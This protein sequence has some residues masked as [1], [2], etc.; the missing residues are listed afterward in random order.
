M[1]CIIQAR[2]SSK[3]LPGKI[4]K[5]VNSQPL[6]YYLIK[7]IKNSTKIKKIIVATSNNYK[8]KKIINYCKKNNINWFSGPLKNVALRFKKIIEVNKY[9]EFMRISA[10]SPLLDYRILDRAI[11]IYNKAKP[12]IVSNIQKRSFPKGQSVEIVKKKIF[13]KNYKNFKKNEEFEH[14]TRYFYN[15]KSKFDI[16]NFKYKKNLSKINLSVDTNK[17]FKLI[18]KILN[19][20]KNNNLEKIL[21]ILNEK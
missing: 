6:L 18:K 13:L 4:L 2:M 19:K 8:D 20:I 10:D 7:S 16:I 3:R 9:N 1:L 17:D 5:K 15:N 12:D 14:V 11:S 21:K